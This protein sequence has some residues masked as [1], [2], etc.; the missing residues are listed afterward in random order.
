MTEITKRS[1]AH[2][3]SK[4]LSLLNGFKKSSRSQHKLISDPKTAP[5]GVAL[6]NGFLKNK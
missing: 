1:Y 4:L 5:A 3:F 2:K 6:Y